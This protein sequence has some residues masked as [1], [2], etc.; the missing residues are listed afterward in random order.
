MCSAT[1]VSISPVAIGVSKLR[2]RSAWPTASR[3]QRLLDPDQVEGLELTAHPLRAGAVPLLV[4][5]DH[6]RSVAE[7]LAQRGDPLEVGAPVGLAD[8]DLD[9]ADP[10]LQRGGRLLL[11]LLDR[12]LQEAPDVL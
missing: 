2:L 9:A 11:D 10:G 4:G 12:G 3:V 7:V 6:Q 5:V 1:E 8:L